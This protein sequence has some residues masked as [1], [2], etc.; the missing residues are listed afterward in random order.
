MPSA[1]GQQPSAAS[2]G[3]PPPAPLLAPL[4]HGK[5][6]ILSLIGVGA[7]GTV[8]E[9]RDERGAGNHVAIKILRS[10]VA[11][12]AELVRTFKGEAQRLTRLNHPNIVSWK[13]F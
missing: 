6:R 4:P 13:V 9:A 1:Q 12:A 3:P 8:Y 11:H 7:A 5:Y 2:S 10:G